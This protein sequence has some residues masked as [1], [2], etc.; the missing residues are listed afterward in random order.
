[1]R[2]VFKTVTPRVY[3][4][5]SWHEG[6][7]YHFFSDGTL[8][9]L[10]ADTGREVWT[11]RV[12][13]E[14]ESA[15]PTRRTPLVRN[16][17]V[18]TIDENNSILALDAATG[19]VKGIYNIIKAGDFTITGGNTLIAAGAERVIALNM[20]SGAIIWKKDLS[21]GPMQ[22]VFAAGDL[23]FVLS[24]RRAPLLGVYFLSTA[25]GYIEALRIEDGSTAW[26]KK[27]SSSISANGASAQTFVTLLP[28][29]G[30]LVLFKSP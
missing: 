7:L 27:L 25:S 1:A 12:V 6:R 22:S 26:E 19:E 18:Y 17:V 20:S 8:V 2:R 29:D 28:D 4:S 10:S 14:F 21:H 16:G 24:N 3:A 13:K 5:P 23:L 9:C 11:R 30:E 15:E